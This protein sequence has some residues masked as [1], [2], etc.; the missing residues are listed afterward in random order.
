MFCYFLYSR[1]VCFSIL[2][3][4]ILGSTITS[5]SYAMEKEDEAPRVNYQVLKNIELIEKAC[6]ETSHQNTKALDELAQRSESGRLENEEVQKLKNQIKDTNIIQIIADKALGEK[7][8]SQYVD[9]L[10]ATAEN[11]D[12]YP[13][14]INNIK[15][16]AKEGH[17]AAQK[18]LGNIYY[19]KEN[20][21]KAFKWYD[22]AVKNGD[23]NS[24]CWLASICERQGKK[25][26]A[27]EKYN[28]AAK[29]DI[30][31]GILGVAKCYMNGIGVEKNLRQALELY[32]EVLGKDDLQLRPN[33]IK[34]TLNNITNIIQQEEVYFEDLKSEIKKFFVS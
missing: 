5:H 1:K 17:V 15:K 34:W 22:A 2:I 30:P 11:I 25:K 12:N 26:E 19:E 24:Q 28:L 23:H 32:L 8:N 29:R 6:A 14:I 4:L 18:N 21:E 20:F 27:F 9:L 7:N 10:I 31:E 3:L 33:L 13:D 16:K